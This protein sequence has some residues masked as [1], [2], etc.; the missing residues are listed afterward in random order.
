MYN[1]KLVTVT[2]LMSSYNGEQFIEEQIESILNQEGVNVNLLI[3]DDGSS[4]STKI[5]LNNYNKLNNVTVLFAENIGVVGSFLYLIDNAP[6]SEYYALADQDDI[7]YPDKLKKA[8]EMLSNCGN[9]KPLLYGANQNCVDKYKNFMS[10][11]FE[12]DISY[13]LNIEHVVFKNL[14]AGCTM[15]FNKNLLDILKLDKKSRKIAFDRMHDVWILLI[16]LIYGNVVYDHRPCMDYRRHGNNVSDGSIIEKKSKIIEYSKKIKNFLFREKD[17]QNI[18]S[19][20]AKIII[21]TYGNYLTKEQRK[22]MKLLAFYKDNLGF[23]IKLIR[24]KELLK[25]TLDD[26]FVTCSKIILNR[27]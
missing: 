23:K 7:W 10:L 27:Y 18:C 14:L 4:D 11:H 16:A 15:V 26:K 22:N 17:K 8:V 2:V 3:R 13:T 6:D 21:N 20:T 1:K 5:I 9:E 25:C 24:N 19:K 12:K